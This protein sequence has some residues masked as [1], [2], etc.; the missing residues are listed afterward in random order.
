MDS[1]IV[2]VT[3][4]GQLSIPVEF[5][6]AMDIQKGDDLVIVRN[7]DT[8]MLKKVKQSE[9]SYLLEAAEPVAERLWDNKEDEIWNDV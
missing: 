5:R 4:K 2:R 9:F 6:R 3:D 1:K 8:L 7:N